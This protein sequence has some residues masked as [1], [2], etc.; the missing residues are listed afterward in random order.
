MEDV[1]HC[2]GKVH[3]L[4]HHAV[5]KEDSSTTKVRVVFDASAKTN[6]KNNS[7]ND[8]L[9][10]GPS[11]TPDLIG[12][13]VRFRLNPAGIIADVEKAFLQLSLEKS[14]SDVIRF[15]WLNNVNGPVNAENL[16]VYRFCRVPFG[17]VSSPFLLS[18]TVQHHL[19]KTMTN[20]A[21]DL[22][23]HIYVDNVLTGTSTSAKAVIFYKAAKEVFNRASM[24][25]R[26][27]SSNSTE[28]L[29][30]MPANDRDDAKVQKCLGLQWNTSDDTVSVNPVDM[31]QVTNTKRGILKCISRFYDPLGYH[32]PIVVKAKCLLQDIWRDEYEWDETL[33]DRFLKQW[34]E[35]AEE[36]QL[37]TQV[38]IPR[39]MAHASNETTAHE[40]HVFSF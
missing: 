9:H 14:D 10:K 40:L 36:L 28:F 29:E 30:S 38:K 18:A 39:S 5:F 23:T 27:W 17:V 26:S 2:D 35:V 25:L 13:L 21:G 11:L 4:P 15:F 33:P 37:A 20:T 31:N 34:Q 32:S 8:F 24:N 22:Q 19:A 3:Y 16:I 1:N 6:V 12:V 7:L